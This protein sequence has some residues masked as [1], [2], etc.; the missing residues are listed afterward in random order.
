M[1]SASAARATGGFAM[2]GSAGG[3]AANPLCGGLERWLERRRAVGQIAQS[4][5]GAFGPLPRRSMAQRPRLVLE[6]QIHRGSK[7]PTYG[8][9]GEQTAATGSLLLGSGVHR[10]Q[11]AEQVADGLERERILTRSKHRTDQERGPGTARAQ[12]WTGQ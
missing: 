7:L 1:D 8:L 3:S 10:A 12:R 6:R 4:A 9:D 5:G 2:G 11:D